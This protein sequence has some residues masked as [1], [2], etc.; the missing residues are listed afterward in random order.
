MK[1]IELEEGIYLQIEFGY[2]SKFVFPYAVGIEMLSHFKD[3]Y[4]LRTPFRKEHALTQLENKPSMN[5][6]TAEAI[7]E[8]IKEGNI[9]W[10]EEQAKDLL[11]GKTTP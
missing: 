8:E 7:K 4:I 3:A 6:R 2:D 9:S 1:P 11:K 10:K 5:I